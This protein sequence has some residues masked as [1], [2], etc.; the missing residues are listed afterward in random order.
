LYS[1]LKG[2][3]VDVRAAPP[4][5]TDSRLAA[6][7]H[8]E[9]RILVTNDSDF[10]NT[11]SYSRERIFAVVLLRIPQERAQS[12]LDS[13]SLLLEARQRN[14]D[15]AGTITILREGRFETTKIPKR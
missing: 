13:F 15:F 8:A 14:T 11:A 5:A 9:R 4:G 2:K 12:L 1:F 10:G 3:G 7:S 6:L